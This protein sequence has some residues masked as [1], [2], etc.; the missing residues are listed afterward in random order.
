[1]ENKNRKVKHRPIKA[2]NMISFR[3]VDHS[4]YRS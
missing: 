1:M 4:S 2:V 3:Q